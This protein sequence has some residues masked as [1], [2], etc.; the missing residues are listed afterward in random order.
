VACVAPGAA[1]PRG[2]TAIGDSVGLVVAR[3]GHPAHL[4]VTAPRPG[5]HPAGQNGIARTRRGLAPPSRHRHQH[6]EPDG[7]QPSE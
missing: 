4:P 3:P 6:G 7:G 2:G 5:K 1:A